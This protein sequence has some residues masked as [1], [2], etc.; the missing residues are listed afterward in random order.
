METP[1][2]GMKLSEALLELVSPFGSYAD[3]LHTFKVLIGMGVAAW[4]LYLLDGPDRESFEDQVVKPFLTSDTDGT[5]K[6]MFALLV[7]RRKAY[8]PNDRRFIVNYTVT[9]HSD[10]FNVRVVGAMNAPI[11]SPGQRNE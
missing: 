8:F 4:N 11:G 3:T 7:R 5:G 6:E 10:G 9:R 1:P 2:D